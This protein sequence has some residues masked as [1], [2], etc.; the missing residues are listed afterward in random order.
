VLETCLQIEPTDSDLPVKVECSC[1]FCITSIQSGPRQILVDDNPRWTL[2]INRPLYV[3][4]VRFCRTCNKRKRFV[5]IK[6]EIS[7][8]ERNYL[9]KFAQKLQ[10][11]DSSIK[12]MLRDRLPHSQSVQGL[13]E[14]F[15]PTR[16]Y[17]MRLRAV[18]HKHAATRKHVYLGRT[19]DKQ[20]TIL[21]SVEQSYKFRLSF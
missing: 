13:H 12:A 18:P 11:F 14:E 3:E 8:V 2:Y 17:L 19:P 7:S 15:P 10:K 16:Q 4:R 21:H 6:A 1:I 5:P 9:L 20:G